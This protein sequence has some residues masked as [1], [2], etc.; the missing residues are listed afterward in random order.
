MSVKEVVIQDNSTA[1]RQKN[2]ILVIFISLLKII[3]LRVIAKRVL[4][5]FWEVH[6][7]SKQ[8]LMA[9]YQEAVKARW[10]NPNEVKAQYKN[11]S[12]LKGSRVVFNIC[13]NKYRL[14]VEINYPRK[15]IFIRFIGS[16]DAYDRINA[17]TI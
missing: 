14:V 10:E 3:S 9:W 12:I 5:E 13:G 17:N 7:D 8:H 16:H 15:W 11:A 6:L 4:R 1:L 2:T